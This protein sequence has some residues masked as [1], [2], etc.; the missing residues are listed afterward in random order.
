MKE[1]LHGKLVTYTLHSQVLT[2]G[3]QLIT[4]V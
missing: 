1:D 3:F 4:F 2:D